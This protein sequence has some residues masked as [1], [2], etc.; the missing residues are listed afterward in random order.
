MGIKFIGKARA[1]HDVIKQRVIKVYSCFP[2]LQDREIKVGS[3]TFAAGT[4][5]YKTHAK[6]SL[7]KSPSHETIA[8]EF[9]HLSGSQGEKATDL[10]AIDHL[11]IELMDDYLSY[12]NLHHYNKNDM[13]DREKIKEL[14]HKAL[15]N[16]SY[17]YIKKLESEFNAWKEERENSVS[18]LLS[19]MN[20]GV[21][22][23][24]NKSQEPHLSPFRK[25]SQLLH[26]PDFRESK[27]SG[28]QAKK[29]E[30]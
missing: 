9:S 22:E 25:S 5:D 23:N 19:I 6:I 24:S 30:A 8:H 11:P 1:Y 16:R 27:E 7:E 29:R 20:N 13:E 2:E 14:A 28:S 3:T 18:S 12:L 15:N 4:A 10:M 21:S 17:R 26:A